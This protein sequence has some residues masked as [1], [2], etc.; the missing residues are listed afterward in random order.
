MFFSIVIP[1]YNR[2]HLLVRALDSILNQ[3]FNADEFEV[4][5]V[6]NGSTDQTRQV[7]EGFS[8]K[9]DK[10]SYTHQAAPGLH[11]ARHTGLR[12]AKGDVVIFGDDD[13]RCE[14][15][16]LNGIAGAFKSAGATLATGPCRPEYEHTPPAWV[17][18]LKEKIPQIPD[19]WYLAS[20]S[21]IDLG[22]QWLQIPAELAFGCNYSIVRKEVEELGGFHPDSLPQNFLQYRGD[23]ETALSQAVSQKGGRIIYSPLAAVNHWVSSERL[24]I[25][26]IYKRHFSEGVTFSYV[27]TRKYGKLPDN[28]HA[29]APRFSPAPEDSVQS[30]IQRGVLDGFFY[31]QQQL[32][33]DKNL[34]QWIFKETYLEDSDLRL[35]S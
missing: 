22:D 15:T 13:I 19:A 28:P 8:S 6:D 5:V 3:S 29:L 32:R 2:Q 10:F 21:I 1:T 17:E 24:T 18:T 20:Y 34:L 31:H 35:Q 27:A 33:S 30:E 7:A 12:A 9:F 23:G 25:P 16:W 14:P 11:A 26:Y 4:I